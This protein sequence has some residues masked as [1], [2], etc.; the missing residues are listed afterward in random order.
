MSA[1]AKAQVFSF[2]RRSAANAECEGDNIVYRDY[3]DLSVVATERV[4]YACVEETQKM[5]LRSN[6]DAIFPFGEG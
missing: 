6:L 5:S 2:C 3:V 4:S 1:F